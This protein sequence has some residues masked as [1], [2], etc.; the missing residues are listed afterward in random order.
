MRK[1][2]ILGVLLGAM[3]F[4][5]SAQTSLSNTEAAKVFAENAFHLSEVM[6]HDVANPPAA[7]RFY[8][9]A[10][11]GAYYTAS[12]SGCDIPQIGP[13][14][15][16]NPGVHATYSA[17]GF[18]LAFAA[19]YAMLEVGKKI[20]PS[21]Y[22]LKTNQEQLETQF[23]EQYKLSSRSVEANKKYAIEIADQIIRYAKSDGYNKLSTYTRYTPSKEEG[24]WYPTP[25]E[26][27]SAIEPQWKTIRPFFLESYDQFVPTAPAPFSLDT[28]SSFFKQTMEVYDVV[29]NLTPEQ[30][31][32]ASFWDCNP[33]AVTYSGHMAIGLK[34]ISPGGHWMGIAGIACE[35]ADIPF[36]STIF[37]HAM[38]GTTLHD[39]F[40]SCWDEKYRSDR[41]R[42]ET[43]IN[44]YIDSEWRPILQTPPFPEYTSGHSVVSAASSVVLTTLLGDN[45]AFR[46]DSEVY[47]GLPERD[48]NSFY[49]AAAEAAISRLYGGIHYRDACDEG[50][51]QGRAVGTNSINKVLKPASSGTN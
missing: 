47:F 28:A 14:F 49:E 8:A 38:V 31:L 7:S 45:F 40:I 29:K 19:T 27:M 51:K 35:K 33:F 9:Y 18:D 23:K 24:R 11:L 21:G 32:I 26:Y 48:F 37:V 25:P 10:M 6:L 5:G 2:V 43:M 17:K 30:K 34:K 12:S 44:K 41:I 16:V 15:K 4:T 42:P 13:N 36:D 46:D 3:Q 50:V 1:T 20:M 22:L 39:A